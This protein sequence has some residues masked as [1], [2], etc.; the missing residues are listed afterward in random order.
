MAFWFTNIYY[1]LE[2]YNIHI[3]YKLITILLKFLCAYREF[4]TVMKQ[5]IRKNIH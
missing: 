5:K 2:N 4:K 3:K 1:T